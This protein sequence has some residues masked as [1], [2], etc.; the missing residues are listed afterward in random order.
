MFYN[1]KWTMCFDIYEQPEQQKK[2]HMVLNVDETVTVTMQYKH[3]KIVRLR[4]TEQLAFLQSV[5][6]ETL[7]LVPRVGTLLDYMFCHLFC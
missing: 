1:N 7:P 4:R 2:A 3:S 5:E 6:R